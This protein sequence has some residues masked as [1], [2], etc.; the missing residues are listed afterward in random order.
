MSRLSTKSVH[1]GCY[2]P[3]EVPTSIAH[4]CNLRVLARYSVVASVESF[5]D[6]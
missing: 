2:L 4:Y 5:V 3:R 6:E 1:S